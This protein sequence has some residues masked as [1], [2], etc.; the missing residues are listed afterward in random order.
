MGRL[1]HAS[2]GKLLR[3]GN[4]AESIT[5][6]F[7]TNIA[8]G[9][10]SWITQTFRGHKY[11]LLSI[12][13]VDYLNRTSYMS[14][15][16]MN[17]THYY[18]LYN[19]KLHSND[20]YWGNGT[21]DQTSNYLVKEEN[22]IPYEPFSHG[23]ANVFVDIPNKLITKLLNTY[24]YFFVT[25]DYSILGYHGRLP[26]GVDFPREPEIYPYNPMTTDYVLNY[27]F[28]TNC[29]RKKNLR[30]G[31]VV[32]TKTDCYANV[33]IFIQNRKG[34]TCNIKYNYT[35]PSAASIVNNA[36]FFPTKVLR[37]I[38]G[39]ANSYDTIMTGVGYSLYVDYNIH[40]NRTDDY[41]GE[42][43]ITFNSISA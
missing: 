36:N 10:S 37:H 34:V 1:I 14:Y 15:D 31:T 7:G 43:E 21:M 18:D 28:N 26:V 30:I 5:K 19:L 6:S 33:F 42:A 39:P 8:G 27:K 2:D 29:D 38:D 13:G 23:G 32:P 12:D 4:F 22:V 40:K 11:E 16:N 35:S 25:L 3:Y 20:G 17:A 24:I 9:Y 41:A